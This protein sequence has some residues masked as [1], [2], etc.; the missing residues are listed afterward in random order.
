LNPAAVGA[1]LGA[2]GDVMADVYAA[3]VQQRQVFYG[4]SKRVR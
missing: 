1:N 2:A 3:S 4:P